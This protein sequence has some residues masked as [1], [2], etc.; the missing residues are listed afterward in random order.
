MSHVD[1][2][3]LH[4]YLDGELPSAERAGV[5]AHL[6]QCAPCRA[7]LEEA[8]ALLERASTLLGSVRPP[9]RAI[10]PFEALRR[11]PRRSPWHV[12]TPFAWAASIA[13]A[14][15]IGYYLRTPGAG[16][17]APTNAPQPGIVA[18][19]R[20]ASVER[21]KVSAPAATVS[22]GRRRARLSRPP[23]QVAHLNQ[24]GDSGAANVSLRDAAQTAQ[25]KARTANAPESAAARLGR[26]TFRLDAVTVTA[27][28]ERAAP[29]A[30][31]APAREESQRAAT[32]APSSS[33]YGSVVQPLTAKTWPVIDRPV[34]QFLLGGEDPVGL[35]GLIVRD[36]RRAPGPDGTIVVEQ[37]LDS[38]TVIQIFQRPAS[39]AARPDS[40]YAFS[41]L[42]ARFVGRLRVEI[43]GPVSVDSLNR[44]LEQV[45]PLP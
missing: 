20:V 32:R 43:A 13:L 30:A 8:R 28:S 40:G 27:Q 16:G 10:P 14:L 21:Q 22:E 33:I 25:A 15:G 26:E 35:P 7:G 23:E 44:L 19:D 1:E 41:R 4:A 24:P 42:F 36:F 17:P 45:K 12:R 31:P 11:A 29:A 6:A 37:A 18:E 5:E 39:N 3:T 2:G 38:S 34:A 9:E